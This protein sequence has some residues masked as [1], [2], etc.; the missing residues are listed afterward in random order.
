MQQ[1]EEPDERLVRVTVTGCPASEQ[2]GLVCC[3]ESAAAETAGGSVRETGGRVGEADPFLAGEVEEVA[4]RC[5][6]EPMIASGG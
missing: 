6:P 5:E 1:R 2:P 4:Q 3:G